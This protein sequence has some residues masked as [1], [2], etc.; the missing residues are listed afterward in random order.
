[1]L[2]LQLNFLIEKSLNLKNQKKYVLSKNR[3]ECV[4]SKHNFVQKLFYSI[5]I[6]QTIKRIRN[7][8]SIS[9]SEK[10]PYYSKI[11]IIIQF[12]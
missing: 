10:S 4:I 12:K 6:T 5:R 7:E 9:N 3:E 8:N 11:I 2:L 1:M